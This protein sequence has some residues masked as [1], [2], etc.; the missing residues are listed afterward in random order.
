MI[1]D[2]IE[3]KIYVFFSASFSGGFKIFAVSLITY[4]FSSEIV[5]EF[6]TAYFIVMLCVS[7]GVIPL[8]SLMTKKDFSLSIVGKFFWLFILSTLSCALLYLFA[9]LLDFSISIQNI[10]L[11]ACVLLLGA[12]E[13]VRRELSNNSFFKKI[14]Q[15]GMLSVAFF[16]PIFFVKDLDFFSAQVILLFFS[17]CFT[18]PVIF[19]LFQQS[20]SARI[21]GGMGAKEFLKN[22][23]A[24]SVSNATST[25]VSFLLPLLLIYL[26]KGDVSHYLGLVF[27]L[28]SFFMLIPR[29]MAEKNIPAMRRGGDFRAISMGAFKVTFLYFI[30][31]AGTSFVAFYFSAIGDDYLLYFLL[32]LSLQIT[33]LSLPFSNVLMVKGNFRDLLNINICGIAPFLFLPLAIASNFDGVFLS[34]LTVFLYILSNVLKVILSWRCCHLIN[35]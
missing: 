12:Y 35:N 1:N 18:L 3:N 5:I 34:Y 2:T 8:A 13:I 30:F 19:G 16:L 11:Y 21:C 24:A 26:L 23:G 33:Q 17:M 6:N 7:F 28:A 20:A 27:S 32:F 31:L 9:N 22:Y 10:Y 25:L 29:F 15:G 14:F 4:L